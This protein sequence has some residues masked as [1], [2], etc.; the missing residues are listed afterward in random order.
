MNVRGASL[1]PVS[2]CTEP[3]RLMARMHFTDHVHTELCHLSG[4]V[5]N[6]SAGFRSHDEGIPASAALI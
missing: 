1:Q 3:G 5:G 4:P 2:E 6:R